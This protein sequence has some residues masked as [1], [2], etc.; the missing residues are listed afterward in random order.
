[1]HL[2][3]GRWECHL[4]SQWA[5]RSQVLKSGLVSISLPDVDGPATPHHADI[6]IGS[7]SI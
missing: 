6:N 5:L 2:M 3:C 1:M 4:V 7:A